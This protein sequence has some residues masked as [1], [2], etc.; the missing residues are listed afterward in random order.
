MKKMNTY[1][2]A[3]MQAKTNI[4]K[5]KA[6]QNRRTGTNPVNKTGAGPKRKQS[7]GSRQNTGAQGKRTDSNPRQVTVSIWIIAAILFLLAALIIWPHINDKSS[8]QTGAAVPSGSYCYGIDISRYQHDISWDSLMVLTDWKGRTIYSKTGAKDIR[9]ISFVF[10]KATEGSSM[11]DKRFHKHWKNAS[12]SGARRGAYHFFRSSKNPVHQ[13]E[14][15]IKTVGQ[16]SPGDLPPV[17]DI[18][19]MHSGC[20]AE[21]LNDRALVWLKAIESHY[22]RKPIVYSSASF[23]SDILCDEIKNNYPVWVAH[24]NST[25]PRCS[26]WNIWQFTDKAVVYGIDGYVDMNVCSRSFLK[27]L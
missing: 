24:Y 18:E 26:N 8:P 3:R 9:P 15:F 27:S 7:A 16:L 10:I 12:Q 11:K 20:T 6:G 19:T 22:G 23:I 5:N 25:A 14:N 13:A 21:M 2:P 1:N 4:A 17:L